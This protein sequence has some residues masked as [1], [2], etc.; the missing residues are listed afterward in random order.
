M[1]IEIAH[2]MQAS[3]RAN[4]TVGR[5]GGDEF[6]LLLTNIKNID[7]YQFVL[8]RVIDAINI[9]VSIDD[10]TEVSVGASIGV[11]LFPCD[12]DDPDKLLR[13]ADQAMYQAK[14]SG[15]NRVCLYETINP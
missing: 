12:R 4:D 2:R 8:Q 15:R 5:F 3:V 1:L 11:T 13:H 9:P 14:K 10:A 6:V 7:E